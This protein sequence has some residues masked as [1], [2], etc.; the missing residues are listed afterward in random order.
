MSP[1]GYREFLLGDLQTQFEFRT[2]SEVLGLLA[3]VGPYWP[4]QV[5]LYL[6]PHVVC[7]DPRTVERTVAEFRRRVAGLPDRSFRKGAGHALLWV[8]GQLAKVRNACEAGD[9]ARAA[10]ASEWMGYEVARFV[11]LA[12]RRYYRY[13]DSRWLEESR[14]FPLLPEGYRGRM[15]R[16]LL[17]RDR[18]ELLRTA[19]QLYDG[20][21][22][23]AAEQGI[24]MERFEAMDQTRA[25]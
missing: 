19:S 9:D 4:M 21:V 8:R 10:Q 22:A 5:W 11:A 17:S 12:N 6:E 23:L 1:Y 16:L 20:C 24:P 18:E 15:A 3:Q 14:D 7:G 13:A 25:W 2:K